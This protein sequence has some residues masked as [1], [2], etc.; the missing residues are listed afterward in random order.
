MAV[1]SFDRDPE[2]CEH[3]A[4]FAAHLDRR[5]F[6]FIYWFLFVGVIGMLFLSSWKYSGDLEKVRVQGHEP[7]SAGYKKRMRRCMIVCGAYAAVSIVAVVME[8]YA[9]LALQ[10]CDGE[11]LMSLYWSTWTMMQVGSLIAIFGI[12]LSVTNSLRGNQNPPW[13][14]A[15][16]TPVLVVAGIGHAVH[17]AMRKRVRQVRSRSRSRGREFSVSSTIPRGVLPISRE[18]TLRADDSER[19]DG[20]ISVKFLGFTPGGAPI[21]KF[22]EDPGS[23]SEADQSVVIGRSDGHVIIGSRMAMAA[24]NGGDSIRDPPSSSSN[25]N[26]AHSSRSLSY[27]NNNNNSNNNN[28]S[29]SSPSA[30]AAEPGTV[31]PGPSSPPLR[32]PPLVRI[33]SPPTVLPWDSPV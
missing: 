9:L 7:G 4:A 30:A 31:T 21:V 1:G 13:A 25:N 8:V 33:A 27:S 22:A 17:G 3:Y 16:G 20:G 24:A 15:L 19:E 32:A 12:L 23:S 10:F 14:L 26:S 29:A 5:S 11:D 2:L 18:Q 6:D 28:S